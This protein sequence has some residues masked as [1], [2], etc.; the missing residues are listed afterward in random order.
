VHPAVA[1]ALGGV[2]AERARVAERV[3][4]AARH[5]ERTVVADRELALRALR[6]AGAP[7]DDVDHAGGG[8]LAEHGALRPLQH[9]DAL[10]LA[11]VAEA[12]AVAR[13]VDA[14]DHD[15]DRGLQ[16][17]VVAHGADAADAGGGD[18]LALGAG[19]GEAGYQDLHVLDVVHA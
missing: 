5:A 6:V 12:D 9:F 10:D 8:V 11:E 16:A 13:P 4:V 7:G 14:V 3:V 1:L 19:H 15:A 17:H 2:H 18:R